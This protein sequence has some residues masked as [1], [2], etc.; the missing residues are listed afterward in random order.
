[1]DKSLDKRDVKKIKNNYLDW[2]LA[3]YYQINLI[4]NYFLLIS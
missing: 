3:E 4:W 1:M 2:D